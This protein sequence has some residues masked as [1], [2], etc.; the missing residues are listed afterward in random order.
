M[1]QL[2]EGRDVSKTVAL[3]FTLF[4]FKYEGVTSSI[5]RGLDGSGSGTVYDVLRS[6]P[7]KHELSTRRCSIEHF[8]AL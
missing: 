5:P 8:V 7:P 6:R 1:R 2:I 3:E 4:K